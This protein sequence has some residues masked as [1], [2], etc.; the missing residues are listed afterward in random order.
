MSPKDDNSPKAHP[1]QDRIPGGRSLDLKHINNERRKL[2]ANA[3][4][5]AS[6]ACITIGVATPLAGAIYNINGFRQA[7]ATWE[8]AV[9]LLGWLATA[10][11]LHFAARRALK[12]LEP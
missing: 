7:L 5:R 1:D 9:G 2:L 3:V 6:T 12:G 4:D 8:L 11:A 10:I